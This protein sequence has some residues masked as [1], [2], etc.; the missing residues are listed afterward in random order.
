[1]VPVAFALPGISARRDVTSGVFEL[2]A[3]GEPFRLREWTWGE[4]RRMVEA[5]AAGPSL[6]RA[7]FLRGLLDTLC[8][9]SPPEAFDPL[10]GHVVLTLLG[11]RPGDRPLSFERAELLMARHLGWTPS[12]IDG[13]PAGR[14]DQLVARLEQDAPLSRAAGG[15]APDAG[16]NRIVLE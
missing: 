4:R 15:A 13:E 12:M 11:V 16:W 9:P 2:T 5:A 14:L 10:Y 6:D 3:F 1:M 8:S 7:V